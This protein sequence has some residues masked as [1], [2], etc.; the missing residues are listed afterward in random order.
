MVGS[1]GNLPLG[2]KGFAQDYLRLELE[3][4]LLGTRYGDL[5]DRDLAD[6]LQKPGSLQI[7]RYWRHQF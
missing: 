6:A 4:L 5:W 2:E 7:S 3:P 1:V